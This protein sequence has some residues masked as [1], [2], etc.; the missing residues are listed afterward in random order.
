MLGQEGK[1]L[2]DCFVC[3]FVGKHQKK[4]GTENKGSG[5]IRE[6]TIDWILKHGGCYK[7]VC[8]VEGITPRQNDRVL[9]I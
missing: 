5:M 3:G 7:A 9:G 6:P 4:P 8:V 1:H 2:G